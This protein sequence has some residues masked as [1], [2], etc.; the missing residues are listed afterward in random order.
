M[1]VQTQKLPVTENKLYRAVAMSTQK[2]LQD[3]VEYGLKVVGWHHFEHTYIYAY[4]DFRLWFRSVVIRDYWL[5]FWPEGDVRL[6][7]ERDEPIL[8]MIE[9][10]SR[11]LER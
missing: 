4:G 9:A 8:K 7:F 11:E 1:T 2:G 10:M 6:E 5:A 3:P